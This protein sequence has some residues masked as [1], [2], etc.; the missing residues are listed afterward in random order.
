MTLKTR[1]NG[2]LFLSSLELKNKLKKIVRESPPSKEGHN[3]QLLA[4]SKHPLK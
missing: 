3:N 4:R 1:L 2:W